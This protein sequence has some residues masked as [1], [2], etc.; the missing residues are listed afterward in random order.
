ML[1]KKLEEYGFEKIIMYGD[2]KAKIALE[3]SSNKRGKLVLITSINPTPYGEGKTTISIGLTDAFSKLGKKSIVTLREPSLGPVFGVKGGATGGGRSVVLPEDDINFHFTGDMHAITSANNL[4]AAAIDNHLYHGNDLKIDIPTISFRRCIDMNDR[5]LRNVEI[6]I[7]KGMT[8]TE[9]FEITAASELMA[10][11]CLAKDLDDLYARVNQIYIGNNTSGEKIFVHDLGCTDAVCLLLQDAIKPNAVLTGK[12]NLAFVHGGPFANVAHGCASYLSTSMALSHADYVITEAGFGSD[13]GG[14]KFFDILGR[15]GLMPDI[16]VINVTIRALKYH[17][18]GSLQ[19]GISNLEF[20]IQNMKTFS[21]NIIIAL[22][23][24]EDDL[25]EE[26]SF[27]KEYVENSGVSFEVCDSYLHGGEGAVELAKKIEHILIHPNGTK[28]LYQLEDTL[29]FK[30]ETVLHHLKAGN[31]LYTDE[32]KMK[33]KDLDHISY[34]ICIA[35][36]PNSISSDAKVLG[37]PKD[38]S[39]TVRDVKLCNGAKFI[40]VYLGSI[41]TLPG[42][43]KDANLY[44]MKIKRH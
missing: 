2:N 26:I 36:T 4:I 43:S 12:G 1:K 27:V 14:F 40:V 38:Y 22:N 31:I 5:T 32:A 20:H 41:L 19:K 9:H 33:I 30:I 13:L 3:D 21:S 16:V 34:P 10:I 17:G 8:R 24:F 11:V 37:Y 6:E 28:F 39:V 35:K 15:E 42:L 44:H 18:E 23:Q 7:K 29:T 25:A